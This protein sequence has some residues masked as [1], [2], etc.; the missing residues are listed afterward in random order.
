MKIGLQPIE[1]AAEKNSLDT[2]ADPVYG[3]GRHPDLP[4]REV[5]IRLSLRWTHH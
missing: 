1:I 3:S 5:Q 4:G 2:F